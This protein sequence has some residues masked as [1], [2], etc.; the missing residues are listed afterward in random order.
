[1]PEIKTTNDTV[2]NFTGLHLYHDPLSSC[3][4]R[5][6]MVL[7]EKGLPWKSHVVNLANM[8]HA[9]DEYQSINP[10]GLVPTLIHDGRTYIESI[11]IIQYLDELAPVPSLAP[12]DLKDQPA[13]RTLLRIADDSQVSLKRLTHEFLFRGSGRYCSEEDQRRFSSSH[14]NTWLV[15]FKRAFAARDAN[16]EANLETAIREMDSHFRNL[17]HGLATNRWLIGNRFTLADIAWTPNVHRMH[18]MEWPMTLYPHLSRW[19][20]QL[21]QRP[22]FQQAV[23]DCEPAGIR[24]AFSSYVA[25]RRKEG[26][27]LA[28]TLKRQ[29]SIVD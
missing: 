15:A 1:M 10:N 8:E 4:M 20:S 18:L 2:R 21:Q 24:S 11:D 28:D 16:W 6:R 9:T 3:A 25:Q 22:S 26:T 5:V 12:A 14:K 13:L 17:E 27:S 19:Y 7:A 23:I 29:R